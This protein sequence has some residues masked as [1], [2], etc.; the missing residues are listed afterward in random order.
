VNVEKGDQALSGLPNTTK[1]DLRRPYK[2]FSDGFFGLL[3]LGCAP[4]SLWQGDVA[5]RAPPIHFMEVMIELRCH[6]TGDPAS[7]LLGMMLNKPGRR[8]QTVPSRMS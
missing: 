6:R 5:R 1:S 4:D 2:R 7:D 3:R 8:T